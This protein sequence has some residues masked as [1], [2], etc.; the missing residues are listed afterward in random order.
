M[1]GVDYTGVC[2]VG[3]DEV[4]EAF[5]SCVTAMSDQGEALWAMRATGQD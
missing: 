1:D 4:Q 5:V 2:Y 3:Y